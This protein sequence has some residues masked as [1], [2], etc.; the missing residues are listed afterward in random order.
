MRKRRSV[1]WILGCLLL[2]CPLSVVA[3]PVSEPQPTP[4]DVC[5]N[6][7]RDQIIDWRQG[8]IA[9]AKTMR[10]IDEDTQRQ[11]ADLVQ[12]QAKTVQGLQARI[13]ALQQELDALKNAAPGTPSVVPEGQP[14]H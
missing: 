13:E 14:S 12:Q 6:D 5:R 7:L 10:R 1:I 4:L 2:A 3:Q 11:I 9:S 8:Q